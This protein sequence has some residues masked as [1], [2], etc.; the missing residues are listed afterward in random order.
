MIQKL[1]HGKVDDMKQNDTGDDIKF[2]IMRNPYII[3][4]GISEYQ[5]P[6]DSLKAVKTDIE[7][8]KKLWIEKC[9]YKNVSNAT[10]I[11]GKSFISVRDLNEYINDK[12]SDIQYHKTVDGL[13]FFCVFRSWL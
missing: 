9:G 3:I 6:N 7:N 8:M 10:D 5:P 11:I 4:V 12:V 13:V 2:C 1:S